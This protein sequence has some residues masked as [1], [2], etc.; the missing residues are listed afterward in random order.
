MRRG[1]AVETGPGDPVALV[2][3]EL[4]IEP[5]AVG[6]QL[7]DG[8]FGAGPWRVLCAEQALADVV[9][10]GPALPEARRGDTA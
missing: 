6:R 2:R 10:A 3:G 4:R 9:L 1:F 7:A 8:A 5:F